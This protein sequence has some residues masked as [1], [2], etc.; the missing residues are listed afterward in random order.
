MMLLVEALVRLLELWDTGVLNGLQE[1]L[2]QD[3]ISVVLIQTLNR[4]L[5][6]RNCTGAWDSNHCI[7]AIAYSIL[8][9]SAISCLPVIAFHRDKVTSAIQEGRNILN[10]S[11][12]EWKT[13]Q[14]LWIEKV[15]YGSCNLSEAYCLAAMKPRKKSYA[16]SDKVTNLFDIP[17]DAVARHCRFLST[18]ETFKAV[19]FWKIQAS[20]IEGYTFLPQL[21]AARTD[22][23]P[24]QKGAKN[25]YLN[26]IPCTWTVVNYHNDLL[27]PANLLWDMMVLTVCNFRVDEYMETAGAKLGEDNLGKAKSII[28]DLCAP[29]ELEKPRTTERPCKA[30]A[31]ATTDRMCWDPVQI[32]G[33]DTFIAEANEKY[34][35]SPLSSFRAVIGHYTRAML[36]HP[37]ILRASWTDQFNFR[38]LLRTFLLSH[39]AQIIDNSRFA[40]QT[41]WKPFTTTVFDNPRNSFYGWVHTTGADS[42]SCPFSFAFFTCLLGADAAPAPKRPQKQTGDCFSSVRQKYLA[43]DLCA[44]LAVMSR[45]YNDY[46]SAVRDR[47]EANINSINFPEFHT[48]AGDLTGSSNEEMASSSE[49]MLKE[50][51]LKLAQHER[52][53]AE[54]TFE[55]LMTDMEGK[56]GRIK[57]ESEKQKANAVRLFFEVTKL[58]AD[59]YVARDL[60]NRV[61]SEV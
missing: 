22:I 45:L 29:E 49:K 42:V 8:T 56:E 1:A 38:S 30:S 6:H 19:P 41:S 13:P 57:R 7:E 27:L 35:V 16:W 50:D 46:G 60:S 55:R 37:C 23:L 47:V 17:E 14:Y 32:D 5:L 2:L 11:Q 28:Y 40:T 18:I 33:T 31:K 15:T 58:Y 53:Y 48:Y 4:T 10:R 44:H 20:V 26:L 59:L 61:E 12:D 51:L 54:V 25:E 52:S 3:R 34:S 36:Q 9:L 24:R 43:Q 39:I 21:K